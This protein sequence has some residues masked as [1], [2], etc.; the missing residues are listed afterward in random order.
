MWYDM[1]SLRFPGFFI[2]YRSISQRRL[3]GLLFFSRAF[4]RVMTKLTN[5]QINLAIKNVYKIFWY[6]NN[7]CPL[8]YLAPFYYSSCLCFI[9]SATLIQILAASTLMFLAFW[10]V[11]CVVSSPL[12][13]PFL[14]TNKKGLWLRIY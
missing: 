6:I 2:I 14:N 4:R 5:G 9:Y 12:I 3:P 1:L 7:F 8:S 10:L 11:C 13:G